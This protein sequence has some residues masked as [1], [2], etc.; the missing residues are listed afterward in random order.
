MQALATVK[1]L[2]EL[3][4]RWE[5]E[6]HFKVSN[7]M[8]ILDRGPEA[9]EHIQAAM[10]LISKLMKEV[11]CC[12]TLNESKRLCSVCGNVSAVTASQ[13]NLALIFELSYL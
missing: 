9:Q 5:A 7:T 6:I 8:E 1:E 11:R 13:L 12:P 3:D 2:D 10:K 4:P